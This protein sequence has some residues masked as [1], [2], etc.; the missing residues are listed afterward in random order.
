MKIILLT[1]SF[2]MFFIENYSQWDEFSFLY[3]SNRGYF[4]YNSIEDIKGE[5]DSVEVLDLRGK[6]LTEIPKEVYLMKNLKELYLGPIS[7]LG[8]FVPNQIRY[9][10][11]QLFELKKLE[12][13]DLGDVQIS[14]IPSDI[15]KLVN[16]KILD[17][18]GA[19]I[20]SLPEEIDRLKKLEILDIGCTPLESLPNEFGSLVNL[21]RLHMD[22]TF[23]R[24]LPES[25]RNLKSL[26]YLNMTGPKFIDLINAIEVLSFFA[27]L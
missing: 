9:L 21:K 20:K 22:Q 24:G 1:L 7:S 17:L 4:V 3:S 18:R 12:V 27:K 15:G 14:K 10:P 5:F 6:R 13:L 23:I 16:L 11:A 2:C 19:T 26:E 25:S 8:Y